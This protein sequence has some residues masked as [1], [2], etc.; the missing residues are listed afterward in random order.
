MQRDTLEN[1]T[2]AEGLNV[3]SKKPAADETVMLGGIKMSMNGPYPNE[4]PELSKLIE[5]VNDSPEVV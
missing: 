3:M 4:F 5:K 2:E 1:T